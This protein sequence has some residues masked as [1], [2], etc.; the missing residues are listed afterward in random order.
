[1]LITV[2]DL[3]VKRMRNVG[4]MSDS[5]SVDCI[6]F[7]RFGRHFEL[8]LLVQSFIMIA[9]MLMMLQLCTKI[10]R[11]SDMSAKKRSFLGECG[12][13]L[14]DN[15]QFQKKPIPTPRKDIGNS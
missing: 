11:E 5:H 3:R 9:A 15:E 10:R 2:R 6:L 4:F 12:H 13:D 8:P 1:M 14:F 7:I